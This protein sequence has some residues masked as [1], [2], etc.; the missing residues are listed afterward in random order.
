MNGK[1][2]ITR[3][4]S[5]FPDERIFTLGGIQSRFSFLVRVCLR[6]ACR[7]RARRGFH[8]ACCCSCCLVRLEVL[9]CS[10]LGSRLSLVL[11]CPA[12]PVQS[13]DG[14]ASYIRIVVNDGPVPLTGV[15]GCPL[16]P[17]G[18]CPLATF[19]EAQQ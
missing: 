11:S 14:G 16:S 8:R 3:Q 18:L 19:I 15:R 1:G 17:S 9:T 13:D 10:L 7:P 4:Y 6:F 12:Y 2:S 5:F